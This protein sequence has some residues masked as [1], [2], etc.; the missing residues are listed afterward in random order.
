M[1]CRLA[2]FLT[3]LL[4]ARDG[5]V[6]VFVAGAIIPL[7]AAVGISVDAS[8]GYLLRSRSRRFR[9]DARRQSMRAR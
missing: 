5:A 2:N 1:L 8:R 3:G 7:V 4:R 9:K 6:A